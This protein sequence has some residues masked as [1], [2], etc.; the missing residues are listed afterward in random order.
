MPETENA[1]PN[2]QSQPGSMRLAIRARLSHLDLKDMGPMP[3]KAL[4]AFAEASADLREGNTRG[5]VA[6]GWR[7]WPEMRD[8]APPGL[9][10]VPCEGRFGYYDCDEGDGEC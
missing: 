2:S 1:P 8:D 5:A 10:Y 7:S 6:S 9:V 3:P 4:L